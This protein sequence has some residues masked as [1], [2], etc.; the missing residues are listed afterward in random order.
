MEYVKELLI[1]NNYW[2]LNKSV[3]SEFGVETAFILGV[4]AEAEKMLADEDGWF[5]QTSETIEEITGLSNHK[6]TLCFK[7]LKEKGILE[8]KNKGVPMKRYFKIN[9]ENI[10]KLLFKNFK[11]YNSKILKTNIQNFSNNKESSYKEYNKENNNKNI[12]CVADDLPEHDKAMIDFDKFWEMYDKKV[13]KDSCLKIW[14]KLKTEEKELIFEKLPAYI[15]SQTDKQYRKNPK[16]WLNG[17]CWND[18]II[19]GG[20]NGNSKNNDGDNS[21]D[22]KQGGSKYDDLGMF[23]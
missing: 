22:R 6:Q 10:Q 23:G 13:G 19:A 2:V 1:S 21:G 18:E 9:F 4:L 3:V 16:T 8:Q 5:F 15:K 17:K 7:T 20:K 12:I 14:S 11:N